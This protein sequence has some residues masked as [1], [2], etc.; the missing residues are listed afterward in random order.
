MSA[1]PGAPARGQSSSATGDPEG[2]GRSRRTQAQRRAA[3][4]AAL[5]EATITALVDHGYAKL[6][7]SQIVENAGVTRGAQA[8]Y[9]STKDELVVEALLHLSRQIADDLIMHPPKHAATERAQLAQ[10]LD[11]WW[12]V[13]TGDLFT[14]TAELWIASRTEPELLRHLEVFGR[15]LTSSITEHSAVLAPAVAA[16]PANKGVLTTAM[17]SITGLAFTRFLSGDRVAQRLWSGTRRELL[18]LVDDGGG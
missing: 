2:N 14:A 1:V 17:A 18:R 7:T 12:E 5:L 13:Y 8:H 11:R 3:T 6:T 15:H 9:F 4:R 16:N 10:L